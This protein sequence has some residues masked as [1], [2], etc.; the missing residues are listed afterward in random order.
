[1]GNPPTVTTPTQTSKHGN[2][3]VLLGPAPAPA[4]SVIKQAYVRGSS[5]ARRRAPLSPMGAPLCQTQGTCLSHGGPAMP[6][7]GH[8]FL[9]QEPSHARCGA[10][11]SPM[12]V[13]PC[14]TQGTSLS[15][16]DPP[17]S[18]AGH[19]CLPQGPPVPDSGHCCLPLPQPTLAHPHLA[20]G[21]TVA[22]VR[23]WVPDLWSAEPIT[24]VCKDVSSFRNTIKCK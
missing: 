3:L 16:R 2:Q 6:D 11:F 7:A 10:P 21:Y 5:R 9:P 14:Q 20:G 15:H 22:Q 19:L 8:L 12:G 4:H 18:D 23:T 1:M 17:V 13:Q 24:L